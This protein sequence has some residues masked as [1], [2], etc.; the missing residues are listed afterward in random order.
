MFFLLLFL[1]SCATLPYLNLTYRLPTGKSEMTGPRVA[2]GIGDVRRARSILGAGAMEEFGS[3][4]T[5][6]FAVAEGGG[7]AS[8]LGIYDY[9]QLFKEA[10]KQRLEHDGIMVASGVEPGEAEISIVIKEFFLDLVNRRWQVRMRYEA[11]LVK[12]GR[13]LVSQNI[14]GDGERLKIFGRDQ[15]EELVGEVFTDTVNQLNPRG[16]LAQSGL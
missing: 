8:R 1:A 16:L 4:E 14:N 3:Q 12:N 13:I 15:A 11:R 2:L 6:S 7:P 5:I 10:F 9:P